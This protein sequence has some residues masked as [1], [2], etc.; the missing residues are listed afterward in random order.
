MITEMVGNSPR[1]IKKLRFG[2]DNGTG[3]F[4]VT[5]LFSLVES[6]PNAT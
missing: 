1:D 6:Y 2:Y 3:Q 4:I 5:A